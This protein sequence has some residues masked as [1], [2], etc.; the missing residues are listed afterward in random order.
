VADLVRLRQPQT[1]DCGVHCQLAAIKLCF[2]EAVLQ[3]LKFKQISTVARFAL[4]CFKVCKTR[5]L[6]F[7]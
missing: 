3:K 5:G 1:N 6:N 2:Y 4:F 7:K